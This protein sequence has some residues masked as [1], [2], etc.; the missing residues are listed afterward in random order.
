MHARA[1]HERSTQLVGACFNQQHP[2]VHRSYLHEFRGQYLLRFIIRQIDKHSISAWYTCIVYITY[3][4]ELMCNVTNLN[5]Y[6]S[7]MQ[8]FFRVMVANR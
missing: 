5:L 2:P 7:T 1:R 3:Y 4:G 6:R 8:V